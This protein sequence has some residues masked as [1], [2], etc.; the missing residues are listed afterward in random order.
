MAN[1]QPQFGGMYVDNF[2]GA[3]FLNI[4]TASGM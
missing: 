1:A 4:P 3:N 2:N